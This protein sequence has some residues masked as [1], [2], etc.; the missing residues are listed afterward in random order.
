MD[1]SPV[2]LLEW[3][4]NL[5]PVQLLEWGHDLSLVQLLEWGHNLSP[6]QLLEWEHV[7]IVWEITITHNVHVTM[8]DHHHTLTTP[9]VQQNDKMHIAGSYLPRQ[10]QGGSSDEDE[11]TENY[12]ELD[13]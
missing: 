11:T 13:G 6:V 7:T 12:E 10:H 4:H 2:Q 5:S 1:L 3:G 9:G 8:G